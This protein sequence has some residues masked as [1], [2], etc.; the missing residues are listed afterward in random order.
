M[1]Q[2]HIELIEHL[3]NI[4]LLNKIVDLSPLSCLLPAVLC[5]LLVIRVHALLDLVLHLLL[6]L[7][8][9]LLPGSDILSLLNHG[10]KGLFELLLLLL[11][12]ELSLSLHLFRVELP[13]SFLPL[14][15][16]FLLLLLLFLLDLLGDSIVP[17]ETLHILESLLDS[18]LCLSC[19]LCLLLLV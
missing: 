18:L 10:L 6:L 12:K 16:F 7:C 4:L 8:N 9:N 19:S 13:R 5:A 3:L 1:F 11:H 2:R 15:L 14:L 17:T